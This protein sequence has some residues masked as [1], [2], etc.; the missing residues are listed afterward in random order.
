[1]TQTLKPYL[2]RMIGLLLICLFALKLGQTIRRGYPAAK[3]LVTMEKEKESDPASKDQSDTEA[4]DAKDGY[5]KSK[6]L[7]LSFKA[8]P[9]VTPDFIPPGGA[10]R[11]YIPWPGLSG[12]YTQ[13]PTRPPDGI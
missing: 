5:E 2:L 11:C 4:G 10:R 12:P 13:E 8:S 3:G 9:A 1:M 7:A 6:K